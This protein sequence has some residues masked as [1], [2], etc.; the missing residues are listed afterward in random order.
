MN[1]TALL[2]HVA[3]THKE[4]TCQIEPFTHTVPDPKVWVD[5]GGEI[6]RYYHSS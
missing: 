4:F 3:Q 6:S 2:I 5:A 1:L